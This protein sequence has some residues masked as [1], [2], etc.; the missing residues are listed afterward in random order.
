MIIDGRKLQKK[1]VDEIKAIDFIQSKIV[2][3]WVG[4]DENTRKFL[5]QK[6]KVARM[7]DV[8]FEI[9]RLPLDVSQDDLEYAVRSSFFTIFVGGI[10]VQLPLPGQ[11]DTRKV[12]VNIGRYKDIDCLGPECESTF[13]DNPISAV[14]APPSVGAVKSI[15]KDINFE[16]L[17]GK[18][19]VLLGYGGLIGR[20]VAAWLKAKGFDFLV[21]R[22]DS[23]VD[24]EKMRER[25][26][27][28]KEADLI[29]AGVGGGRLKIT[30]DMIKSGAVVIDFGP[31]VDWKSIDGAGG[32]VTSTPGG[33]GPVLVAEL[34]RNFAILKDKSKF[35]KPHDVYIRKTP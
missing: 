1:I 33:T 6:E 14:I 19:I 30:G 3:F 29:I 22:S 21:F 7:L 26:L 27:A 35:D 25:D 24:L 20:P 2:G 12:L 4:D 28:L 11:I 31:D 17:N 5:S 34:F 32:I 13:Y 8:E 16:D 18:K 9:K 15:L 23:A 10:I